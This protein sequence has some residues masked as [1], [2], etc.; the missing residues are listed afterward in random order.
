MKKKTPS[1]KKKCGREKIDEG[2]KCNIQ[3]ESVHIWERQTPSL[4]LKFLL[5]RER[6]K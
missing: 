6:R 2:Q 3:N 4:T 5:K 1:L